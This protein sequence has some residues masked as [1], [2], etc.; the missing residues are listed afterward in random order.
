VVRGM[1]LWYQTFWCCLIYKEQQTR[2]THLLINCQVDL[3]S[4]PRPVCQIVKPHFIVEMNQQF[5]KFIFGPNCQ[6]Y[7]TKSTLAKL[8]TPHWP[9]C[10]HHIGQVADTTLPTRHCQH[11]KCPSSWPIF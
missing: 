4:S 7:I 2:N 1:V 3:G 6:I 8:P 10:Q 5:V 9:S 11:A